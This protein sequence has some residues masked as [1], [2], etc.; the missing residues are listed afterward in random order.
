MKQLKRILALLLGL[1][2]LFTGVNWTEDG[3]ATAYAEGSPAQNPVSVDEKPEELLEMGE[4]IYWVKNGQAVV[5]GYADKGV[6]TLSIPARLGGYPVTG[7][8]KEAFSA[9]TALKSIQIPTNVTRIAD[10]AFSGLTGLSIKAYHGAYALKYASQA[11][12]NRSVVGTHPGVEYAEGLVDL[13][14]LPAGSYSKLSDSSVIF[15]ANEATFLTVGQVVYYPKS[16]AYPTGLARK[17]DSITPDGDNLIVTQSQPEWGN[18]FERVSGEEGL[19]LDWSNATYAEGVTAGDMTGSAINVPPLYLDVNIG[20]RKLTGS[21]GI[22]ID[23]PTVRYDVGWQWWG[24]FRIP[25]I[26]EVSVSI[27]ITKK[28]SVKYGNKAGL[29]AGRNGQGRLMNRKT[30]SFAKV[31]A[32]SVS[33]AINGYVS[34]DLVVEV[35]GYIEISAT[36][37]NMLNIT[38]KNGNLSKNVTPISK[39]VQIQVGAELKVGPQ[40][41]FYVVL[42]WASF[43]IRFFELDAGIFLKISGKMTDTFVSGTESYHICGDVKVSIDAEGTIKAGLIKL[44]GWDVSICVKGTL[45]LT[46]LTLFNGHFDDGDFM[47]SPSNCTLKNRDFK[48]ISDGSTLASGK[49]DVNSYLT[50]PN[51]P[52]KPGHTFG[53]WYV[54]T[55][56]SGLPGADYPFHFNTYRMPYCGKNGTFTIYAKFD[57]IPVNSVTLNKSSDTIYTNN[58]NGVQLTPTVKPANAANTSVRWSSS[59]TRVATVNGSGKVMPVSAGTATITCSSVYDPSKRA[60]FTITVRQYV[61]QVNLSAGTNEIFEGETLQ[62]SAN[63][64]PGDASDKNLSWSSSNTSVATVS[65]SG[66]IT[67][68]KCGTAVIT[69]KATDRNTVYGTFTVHILLPVTGIE[70]DKSSAVIYTNNTTGLQLNPSLTPAAASLRS[71]SWTSSNTNVAKVS[72]TGL[73]TPVAPGTATITCRS[74]SNSSVTDTCVITV[75]QYV[76]SVE[77]AGELASIVAGETLQLSTTILPSNATDKSLNWTSSN[78]SV[79]TV[80]NSGIVTGVSGG[81]AV[82]TAT[83]RDG[84]GKKGSYKIVVVNLPATTPEVAVTGVTVPS[85]SMTIYTVNKTAQVNA[86]VSPSNA[87]QSMIWASSNEG[88]ATIDNTGKITMVKGGRSILTGRSASDPHKYANINLRVVQSVETIS[89]SGGSKIEDVGGTLQLT[90]IVGPENAENKA[91]TWTSSDTGV[92]TIDQTGKVTGRANGI[93]KITATAKDGSN[94]SASMWFKVGRDPIPVETVTLDVTSIS[95]YTNEKEGFQ[96]TPTVLPEYADDLSVFWASSDEQVATVNSDGKITFSAPGT[97]TITCR[98]VTNPDVMATCTVTVKQYVEQIVVSGDKSTMIPG[99]TCQMTATV[100]PSNASDKR[101]TWSSS[102][103]AVATVSSSGKVTAVGYGTATIT[104]TAKDGSG[105]SAEYSIEVEKELQLTV[106]VVNDTVYT[107]GQDPCDIAYVSLTNASVKRMADAGNELHWSMTKK[108]GSG[109]TKMAVLDTTLTQDGTTYQTSAAFLNGSIYPTAGTEVYTV[110]CQAGEFEESVDI[111]VTVDGTAYAESVKLKDAAVGGNTFSAQYDEPV[112]IPATPYSNDSKPVPAGMS[113]YC[114]GDSYYTGHT[115]ET[116]SADGITVSFDESGVYTS[117]VYYSKGNLTYTADATFNMADE[118]GVIHLRVEEITLNKNFLNMAEGEKVNLTATVTPSDAYDTTVTWKSSDTKVAKVSSSGRVTAVAPGLAIITCTAADNRTSTVCTVSV[119]AYLQLEEDEAEYTVYPGGTGRANLGIINVTSNSEK[120]L[121]TDGMNVTWKL[122]RISGDNTE[123]GLDEFTTTA[124]DGISVS[125]NR[126]KLLRIKGAGTDVYRLTCSAGDYSD[127]CTIRV[128]A[129]AAALPQ[130][131]TLNT[132][133]YTGTIDETITV[134]TAYTLS[135]AGAALPENTQVTIDGGNA[136]WNAM[137]GLYSYDK[138]EE[139]IFKAAGSFTGYVIFSGDNYSYRCPITIEVADENGIV[140]ATITNVAINQGGDPILMTP[141]DTK[142][143]SVTVEPDN[144]TYG[145]ISWTSSDTAVATVS[146]TGK[147]T[148]IGAGYASITATVPESDLEGS[149][150]IYVEEGINFRNGGDLERTVFIDGE[151][152]MTLD[153]VMLTDNTSSRMS[154]APEWTLRR[155]SGIS[156]TLRAE[157]FETTN[158]QGMT[159]YGCNLKLYSVSKEGDTV[160]ELTCS[161]GTESKTIGITVHAAYRDRLLPASISLDQTVFTA[162]IGELIAVNPTVSTYPEGSKLPNGVLVSCEGGTQY[163][164]ALNAEDT[165]ISQSFSTFSF[166]RAGTFEARF[167]YAYSNMKYVVPVTFR[168]RNENGEVPVQAA[169]MALNH[170]ALYMTSG[171]T[172]TLEAV[173]TPVNSTN[174]AVT[175]SSS[176]PSVATVDANGNI[177][178]VANGTAYIYCDPADTECE[179]AEC[180]VTVENYLTVE[181]GTNSVTMYIQGKQQKNIAAVQLTEGT[182]ERLMRDGIE[183]VWTVSDGQVTHSAIE[184]VISDG[185]I[186]ILVN[187]ESLNSAGTDTYTVRCSAGEYSWSKKFTLK[188]MDLGASAPQSVTIQKTAVTAAVNEPVTIDFTPV[189][190]PSGAAMPSGMSDTGF[191]GV[192]NFYSALD[193]NTYAENDDSVTVAFTMPGQYLLT[194]RYLLSNLE[195]VTAC[196]ITVGGEQ[197]GRNVL[198]ATETSYTVYSGGQSGSVSTVSITDAILYQLWGSSLSWNVE[199]ISGNSMTVALKEHGDSVDVFVASVQNKGTDVWRVSCTFGGMTESVDITLTAADPR[200]ALPESIALTTDLLSGMIG[201][202]IYLPL[203]VSCNPTGSMLPDQ[204]DEFWSFRLDQ[205]GEERSSHSIENGMLQIRFTMSGYYTGFLTYRSGNVSYELPVYFVIQDEEQE[206]R[207]PEL[208]L[209]AVNTFD[210][211]YPE[212]ETGVSIGQMVMAESLSTYSTGGAIAYMKSANAVWKVTVSGTAATLSLRK[213]SDNV[214]DLILNTIKSSGDVTYT[215]KCT[216]GGKSYTVN[217]TLH[218]AGSSEARPDATLMR[219]AYQTA[220]GEE[221]TIDS[222]MYSCADGSILQSSTE[223]D[224]SALLAAVGYEV[225]E[226][227]DSWSMTFY[228]EGTYNASVSAQVSNLKVEVPIVITVGEKGSEATLTVL[229]LPTALTT[230]EEAAFERTA[231]NVID[232]R[233]TKI[234]T[235]GAGAFK[236]SVNVCLVYIPNSVTSIATDAF[237]GCLNAEFCCEADSYAATWA[238][239]HNFPVINP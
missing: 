188:V 111:T 154:G 239:N 18:A 17:I 211:V 176:D 134:D 117:K 148:A 109:D 196:T 114:F 94:V 192:G 100:Y 225:S 79:A 193:L 224:A 118:N 129:M 75:K 51:T 227:N 64:L 60:T 88:A 159:L 190:K 141:G 217:R 2:L 170:R 220:V 127:S 207:K 93:T 69:A 155:V 115:T 80:N 174:Q 119:E 12:F 8:G 16:A 236:N 98:S 3:G 90:A 5:A 45:T 65:Q 222:R 177:S 110:T 52:Y 175:W 194:R 202:P 97:T 92:A 133:S 160:Y 31:P 124:E 54:S 168:I 83:A 165:Y 10:N 212:G 84:S 205:A 61:D 29:D 41:S 102:D 183:P 169:R 66:K 182:I 173:F 32:F 128:N 189:I 27:P 19:I 11:G 167:V 210:T 56:S 171:D 50:A 184:S 63:V 197:T 186:G 143:L 216:V 68:V 235:I 123:L 213:A 147:V 104:A 158:T 198:K 87:D 223:L 62:L 187:T 33:G 105:A 22:T 6:T 180:A 15:K 206:V 73:V 67:G 35:S 47:G 23:N 231:A 238:A 76:E 125:G 108:S 199:R 166:N 150:L 72:N 139:L 116:E 82:I 152:R 137:S 153:S 71:V 237:Y 48:I 36:F 91:V 42:G 7:I 70:L 142:E 221:V 136:F 229:K 131:V 96:L 209:F 135:P 161:D 232:L 233:G 28:L 201:N 178:A 21:I 53:G 14:G 172:E 132:A 113:V 85:S 1:T 200:G 230:I 120:R 214:Y 234:K 106:S 55:G 38:Y 24:I 215:V 191:V 181:A 145:S 81:S 151:T 185:A 122:E 163:E 130:A 39:D 26:R 204:G 218:V 40:L 44:G 126:I 20:G 30:I 146:S 4:W 57:P 157:P 46:I 138:P 121:T 74:K 37:K 144:A 77:V 89:F 78:T 208:Q 112:T 43:S 101:L 9:N 219:T 13:A 164:E 107:Q 99:E 179:T 25:D 195:Y 58:P 59:N 156:L 34:L 86:T 203:G 149:C 49:K 162:D 103:T 140:P 228:Q 95:K 226:K